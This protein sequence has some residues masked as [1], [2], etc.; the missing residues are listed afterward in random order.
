MNSSM[1]LARTTSETTVAHAALEAQ[2]SDG[3]ETAGSA[4]PSELTAYR[5]FFEELM[6]IKEVNR[7]DLMME[8]LAAF[9][10]I[11][12]LMRETSTTLSTVG[13][14][15]QIA[16]LKSVAEKIRSEGD[17]SY[18]AGMMR[19]GMSIASGVTVAG[20]GGGS[21]IQQMN[22]VRKS[23]DAE[24]KSHEISDLNSRLARNQD[25]LAA[26]QRN[27]RDHKG[28]DSFQRRTDLTASM[29]AD[30]NR[31]PDLRRN[32]Q[33]LSQQSKTLETRGNNWMT[34]SRATDAIGGATGAMSGSAYEQQANREKTDQTLHQAASTAGE[35]NKA[36]AEKSAE[37]SQSTVAALLQA[38]RDVGQAE[39]EALMAASRV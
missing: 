1:S 28:D 4:D 15:T 39:G 21:G 32:F 29:A 31:L 16:E 10:E 11:A 12:K 30:D 20:L 34:A 9:L 5:S 6:A 33:E 18:H 26:L 37:A 14:Q 35:Q 7:T 36:L 22:G 23:L 19:G 13:F 38:A 24:R 17:K 2:S 27:G 25:E 3:S 8:F